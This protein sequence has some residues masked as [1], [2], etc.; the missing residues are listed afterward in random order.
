[1]HMYIHRKPLND[2]IGLINIYVREAE[3][4]YVIDPT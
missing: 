4:L 2:L 1:M 3:Y